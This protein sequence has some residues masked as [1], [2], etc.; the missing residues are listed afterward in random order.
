[1]C[2]IS[3][4]LLLEGLSKATSDIS[5]EQGAPLLPPTYEFEDIN[6][7]FLSTLV[8]LMHPQ[9]RGTVKLRSSNPEDA[10]L[11]DF[12][13]LSHP[14]DKLTFIAAIREC[15]HFNQS[16]SMKKFLKGHINVPKSDSD[17][18]IWVCTFKCSPSFKLIPCLDFHCG[19]LWPT[20]ACKWKHCDE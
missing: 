19:Q 2:F 6:D 9:S 15:L 12:A 4:F 7:A 16:P 3:I 14:V 8:A 13:L 18:D 20:L 11:I 5:T 1:M 10:P 17:E